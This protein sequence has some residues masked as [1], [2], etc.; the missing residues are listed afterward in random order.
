MRTQA[1]VAPGLYNAAVAGKNP[2]GFEDFSTLEKVRKELGSE[3]L[4]LP[5]W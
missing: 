5:S 2:F 4:G 3:A 1:L